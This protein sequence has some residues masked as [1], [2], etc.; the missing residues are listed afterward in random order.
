MAFSP[1]KEGEIFEWNGIERPNAYC[2]ISGFTDFNSKARTLTLVL[3]IFEN[4]EISDLAKTD[5]KI[6]PLENI[7]LTIRDRIA[8]DGD[9]EIAINTFSD[10]FSDSILQQ[11]GTV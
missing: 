4:K 11:D 1:L 6:K 2:R 5:K 9:S 8:T 10:Y 3:S 7:I